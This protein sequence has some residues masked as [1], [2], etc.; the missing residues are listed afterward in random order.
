M[1][2]R[3][4][5]QHITNA[6][7]D[8]V[9]I[10]HNHGLKTKDIADMLRISKSSVNYIMQAYEACINADRLTLQKLIKFCRPTVDWAIKITNAAEIFKTPEP[11]PEPEPEI[12]EIDITD[13]EPEQKEPANVD[14][15]AIYTVL[16]DIRNLLL[17]IR[18]KLK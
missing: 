1:E 6:D 15:A 5:K 17:D 2:K 11:E 18:E 14:N 4:P 3:T 16:C 8:K 12:P 9:L 10:L 7:R 13:F